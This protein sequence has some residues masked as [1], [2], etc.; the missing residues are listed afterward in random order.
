VLLDPCHMRNLLLSTIFTLILSCVCAQS[1]PVRQLDS[2]LIGKDSAIVYYDI[3][4]KL[5]ES[6]C[7]SIIRYGHF[8]TEKGHFIGKFKDVSKSDSAF[9]VS[10]GDYSKDGFKDGAF[11]IYYLDKKL[12]AR[13]YFKNG[14][15]DGEWVFYY[16]NGNLRERSSFKKGHY[17]G[18]RE[19]YYENGSPYMQMNIN[20]DQCKI[21]NLWTAD[22]QKIVD[23]G[24]GNC[25]LFDGALTWQGQLVKGRPDGIWT[26]NV[27]TEVFGSELFD[28][29]NFIRGKNQSSI[30]TS[31]YSDKSRIKFSPQDMVRLAI[32][33]A[34]LFAIAD[35]CSGTDYS[36]YQKIQI[37]FLNRVFFSYRLTGSHWQ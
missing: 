35:S 18:N 11:F 19:L 20:G 9:I 6:D 4:Y 12:Q 29:G 17:A 10:G 16:S 27:S 3:H 31:N 24:N 7:A 37:N 2:K 33:N 1:I 21:S 5:I 34:D 14:K 8:D 22:G 25:V 32:F 30:G 15:Y 28:K 36:K 13:G 26:F 23:N